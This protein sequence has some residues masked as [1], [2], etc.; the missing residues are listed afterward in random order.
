MKI[1]LNIYFLLCYLFFACGAKKEAIQT[2]TSDSINPEVAKIE[3][4]RKENVYLIDK[5]VPKAKRDSLMADIITYIY[6]K[7]V[8]AT[9]QNRF[10]PQ[11]RDYYVKQLIQFE[12]LY[13]SIDK[14]STHYFYIKRPARSPKGY[15]RGVA[16]KFKLDK[17][18]KIKDFEEIFNTP[19]LP[20]IDIFE[21]GKEVFEEILETGGIGKFKDNQ[22]YIEFPSQ[23]SVYDKKI[24]EWVY[25]A[26]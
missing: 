24:Y 13:Y 25:N 17:N 1:H 11:F 14:D 19:M 12:W 3:K 10:E 8:E 2:E 7:P 9:S 22:A 21:R 4:I 18:G 16:G 26:K 15:K 20:D 23:V 6:A 5:F